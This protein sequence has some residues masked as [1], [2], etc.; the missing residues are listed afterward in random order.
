MDTIAKKTLKDLVRPNIWDLEPYKCARNEYSGNAMIWLDANENPFNGPFNRYPDPL[1]KDVKKGLSEVKHVDPHNIF[2]GVGSD[3]CIDLCYRVFCE[4]AKDNVVAIA[5]TYGMYEVCADINNVEYRKVPLTNDFELDIDKLIKAADEH[6]KLIWI[7]SPNNPTGNAFH[8]DKI[9]EVYDRFN[10]ILVVDEAYIDFSDKGSLLPELKE[11]PH[12]IILQTFSKAWGS[13]AA[14]LGIAY[15]S[16]EIINIFNKVKYPYNINL[17]TQ[18][19]AIDHLKKIKEVQKWVKVI[20]ENRNIFAEEL[21]DLPCVKQVYPSDSN[22]LLVRVRDA[23]GLYNYLRN[24]GIII[25]NRNKVEKCL[26]CVRITVGSRAENH[27]LL[28]EIKAY[29]QSQQP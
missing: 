27:E 11:M 2:L 23:E 17:L 9:K 28:K 1:Q 24:R 13:A 19:Y 16:E 8:I 20:L 5:P 12:L 25:R 21:K 7:C 22:F 10:G 3:E 29:E 4:P 6:T 18:Q 15:A 26:G 14:R